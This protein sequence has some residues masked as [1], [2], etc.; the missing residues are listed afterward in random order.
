[1]KATK[2]G[3]D[4]APV[5]NHGLLETTPLSSMIFRQKDLHLVWDFPL[6]CFM[7]PEGMNQHSLYI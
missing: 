5:I 6:P 2:L 3:W 1:M 7:T 4:Y